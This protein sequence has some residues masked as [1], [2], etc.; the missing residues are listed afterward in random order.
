MKHLLS[1]ADLTKRE[2]EDIILETFSFK[3][4][5]ERE[6]KKLPS[7][8]GKSIVNLFFESSTRTRTSFEYAGKRLGAD[9]INI[10]VATSSVS[11][12]ESLLD[13][14]KTIEAML[15]DV[16]V[17]RHPSSG[18]P[19]FVSNYLKNTSVVNAGDGTHEHPTQALLDM[20]TIIEGLKGKNVEGMTA[21]IIGDIAHSRVAR[22]NILLMNKMK[23]KVRVCGPGTMIPFKI[24]K[25]GCSVFYN[26]DEALRGVDVIMP[27]RVQKERINDPS[28]LGVREYSAMYG[29]DLRRYHLANK[30]ALLLHPGPLNRGVEIMPDLADSEHSKILNQVTNG[31]ALRMAILFKLATG[32]W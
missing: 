16:V 1:I 32:G 5:L 20:V 8:R 7:L 25:L 9:V 26:L 15:P 14:L 21:L 10:S 13:T 27:L 30:K 31:V 18:A 3:K 23:M 11:K 2:I 17:I 4:V 6:L 29:M 12:G 24:E 22:S 19:Y 28:F